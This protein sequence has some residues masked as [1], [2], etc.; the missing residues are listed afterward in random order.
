MAAAKANIAQAVAVC[1][2]PSRF[3]QALKPPSVTLCY[4]MSDLALKRTATE[5][6]L[7]TGIGQ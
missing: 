3:Q 5:S 4:G 2:E 1:S 6:Q 7:L